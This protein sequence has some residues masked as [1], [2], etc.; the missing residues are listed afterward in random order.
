M[1]ESIGGAWIIT[2]VVLFI[3]LFSGYLAVSINYT[4]AFKVKN[5][6]INTIEQN[7]GFSKYSGNDINTASIQTLEAD[8]TT[9]GYITAYLKSTGYFTTE[10]ETEMRRRC[11]GENSLSGSNEEY[12]YAG[13]Y[14]IKKICN[15]SGY[16][17]PYYK[18]TTF[19]KFQI[20]IIQTAMLIEIN[21]ETKPLFF[22]TSD[23]GCFN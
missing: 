6:I 16:G 14:C 11:N 12:Y 3:V 8:K 18:V 10:N 23:T 9:Q 22:D 13:G 19:I 20:P 1:R 15:Y 2:I 4:K 7:E 5:F 17:A 21:G